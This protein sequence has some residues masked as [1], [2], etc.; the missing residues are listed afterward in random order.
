MPEWK[1]MKNSQSEAERI[2]LPIDEATLLKD[3]TRLCLLMNLLYLCF[4]SLQ[5][6][7]EILVV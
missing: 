1:A 2:Q 4:M 6:L 5:G 7:A 3:A